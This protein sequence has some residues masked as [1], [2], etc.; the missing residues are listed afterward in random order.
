MSI[1]FIESVLNVLSYERFYRESCLGTLEKTE[2]MK[3]IK[4]YLI[5]Y[6][7]SMIFAYSCYKYSYHVCH[8]RLFRNLE[9]SD[10]ILAIGCFIR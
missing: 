7:M 6:V 1:Y 5:V 8:F 2:M 3:M 4:T 10:F 9:S